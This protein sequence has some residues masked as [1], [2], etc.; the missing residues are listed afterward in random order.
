M[1]TTP[2]IKKPT[3]ME[4]WNFLIIIVPPMLNTSNITADQMAAKPSAKF[5]VDMTIKLNRVR[6]I[7][8][9][10]MEYLVNEVDPVRFRN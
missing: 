3:A 6:M 7:V 10:K 2:P 8:T 4:L 9:A 1:A 5:R